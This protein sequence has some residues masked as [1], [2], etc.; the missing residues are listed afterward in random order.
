MSAAARTVSNKNEKAHIHS[1]IKTATN[2]ATLDF[3]EAG[4]SFGERYSF[5]VKPGFTTACWAYLPPHRIYIGDGILEKA[6]PNLTTDETI[7]YFKKYAFH[8][9]GHLLW[10]SRD[11]ITLNK[12]LESMNV[13]FSLFNLFED[14]RIEHRYRN[15]LG[16]FF[17]WTKYEPIAWSAKPLAVFFSLVQFEGDLERVKALASGS[18]MTAE[19]AESIHL[20]IEDV[21]SYYRRCLT[22]DSSEDLYPVLKAWCKAYPPADSFI[23]SRGNGVEGKKGSADLK[24]M[25]DGQLA[26]E[27]AAQ[28][29][30]GTID[31]NP[32]KVKLEGK[33]LKG[34]PKGALPDEGNANLL[35]D[36]PS[37][38]DEKRAAAVAMRL[39][40]LFES[41]SR[42]VTN[43][44]PGKKLSMRHYVTDRPFYRH[45]M[46]QSIARKKVLLVVDCSGSM[47]EAPAIS[48]GRLLVAA[49]SLLASRGIVSGHVVLSAVSNGRTV[50]QRFALPMK[51]DNIQLIHAFGA[52]EGLENAIRSNI[53]L[54]QA[55]DFVFVYTDGQIC[56]APIDKA[57]L[58]LQGVHTWGLYVGNNTKSLAALKEFFDKALVRDDAERLVEAMLVQ[59]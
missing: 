43:E 20:L 32:P 53:K 9:L 18:T 57:K 39:G 12:D 36:T 54:A 6:K 38:I 23:P 51:L 44:V 17:E 47:Q 27:S 11:F 29:D 42:L 15:G 8:E 5:K 52:A 48:E 21:N 40:R 46:L 45:K 59:S 56:D 10:T 35:G 3:L 49:L 58:H 30:A 2:D 41:K 28:F 24:P 37:D 13:P 1:L 55:A 25:L 19:D 50:W 26:Q 7:E 14:A 22:A 31:L 4:H 33:A 34:A 16:T